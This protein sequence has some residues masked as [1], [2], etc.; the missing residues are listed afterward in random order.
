M[1]IL[2]PTTRPTPE[3]V[4]RPAPSGKNGTQQAGVQTPGLVQLGGMAYRGSAA[5][6]ATPTAPLDVCRFTATF[7]TVS[8][9]PTGRGLLPHWSRVVGEALFCHVFFW[10]GVWRDKA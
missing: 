5:N 3:I 4:R 9:P 1:V 7:H 6:H 8:L 2:P 10:H